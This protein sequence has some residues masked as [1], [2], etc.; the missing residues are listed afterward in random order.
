[1]GSGENNHQIEARA[2][3]SEILPKPCQIDTFLESNVVANNLG[4]SMTSRQQ[5]NNRKKWDLPAYPLKIVHDPLQTEETDN[6]NYMM[7]QENASRERQ[8]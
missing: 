5:A 3:M 1:M 2:R 6:I 4:G 7:V 8:V